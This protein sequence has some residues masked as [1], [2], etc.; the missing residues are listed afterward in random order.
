M[1]SRLK[2]ILFHLETAAFIVLL[3]V[4]VKTVAAVRSGGEDPLAAVAQRHASHLVRRINPE[5]DSKAVELTALATKYALTRDSSVWHDLAVMAWRTRA[6]HE[7]LTRRIQW[8]IMDE[9]IAEHE[10]QAR[11]CQIVTGTG[12]VAVMPGS[13][14]SVLSALSSLG[15]NPVQIRRED[16]LVRFESFALLVIGR[17]AMSGT[18]R[19]YYQALGPVLT[20]YVADGGNILILPH[21]GADWAFQWLP[22][23]VLP[24]SRALRD[25]AELVINKAD[26]PVLEAV[27]LS[28]IPVMQADAKSAS[29]TY[30]LTC[31]VRGWKTLASVVLDG[32][33]RAV[34]AEIQHGRGRI[35]LCQLAVDSDYSVC[36]SAS[37]L[38]DNLVR[39][40]LQAPND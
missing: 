3:V 39:Y 35:A 29:G 4:F 6:T 40:L 19:D 16:G 36:P 21:Q 32:A 13:A 18:Y 25:H 17:N 28:D 37:A 38:F 33:A 8:A 31:T 20:E 10:R 9:S 11:V 12:P 26:H 1:K 2:R 27:I 24:F 34:L 22:G 14:P 23:S 15:V 30:P 7:I 5:A